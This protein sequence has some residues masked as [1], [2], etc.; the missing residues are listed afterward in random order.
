MEWGCPSNIFYHQKLSPM[1]LKLIFMTSIQQWTKHFKRKE[2]FH[3][4]YLNHY[5]CNRCFKVFVNSYLTVT[6]RY[7]ASRNY[8]TCFHCSETK[9]VCGHFVIV[10]FFNFL[11]NWKSIVLGF[12]SITFVYMLCARF[13]SMSSSRTSSGFGTALMMYCIMRV[14]EEV[15]FQL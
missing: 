3:S 15:V 12:S 5:G 14:N 9:V 1:V 8:I 13:F 7:F 6:L 2:T 4:F 11:G 10:P